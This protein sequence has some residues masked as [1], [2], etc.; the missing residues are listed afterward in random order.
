M[1][2]TSRHPSAG[3]E[4]RVPRLSQRGANMFKSDS[5]ARHISRADWHYG[6]AILSAAMA[7]AIMQSLEPY[8]TLR[9]PLFYAA[10]LIPL[11]SRCGLVVCNNRLWRI[12][13]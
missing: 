6:L 11:S 9:T 3:D 12:G 13:C 2:G 5:F 7:L 10:I 8:T 4:G 1:T